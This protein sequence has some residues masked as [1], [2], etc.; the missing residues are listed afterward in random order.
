MSGQDEIIDLADE[1][2]DDDGVEVEEQIIEAPTKY[3]SRLGF[4]K[5]MKVVPEWLGDYISKEGV[6]TEYRPLR[7]LLK[8]SIRYGNRLLQMKR[9]LAC[10]ILMDGGG[11]AESHYATNV[12]KM[13]ELSEEGMKRFAPKLF[14]SCFNKK[15][16]LRSSFIR[17]SMNTFISL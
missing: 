12:Q 1:E 4:L 7:R 17:R 5:T 13:W 2:D 16:A 14:H 10:H 6:A 8:R 3:S 15:S 11:K 9:Q